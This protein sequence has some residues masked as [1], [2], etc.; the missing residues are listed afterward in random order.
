MRRRLSILISGAS[1]GIGQALALHLAAQGH[2]VFAG[3]RR[4]ADADTLSMQAGERSSLKPLLLD[5][6][7]A[8]SIAQAAA[9]IEALAHGRLDVLINNAGVAFSAPLEMT[10]QQDL[11]RLMGV[12]VLGAFALTRACLPLLRQARGRI[13]N[14]SSISGVFAAPGLSAYVASKHAMEGLTASLRMELAPV[15]VKVCSIAPGKIDTPI[16]D[17]ASATTD[18]LRQINNPLLLALYKPLFDFY[19][20]YASQEIG[21]P[22]SMLI[23]TVE[24]ALAAPAPRARYIVGRQARWRA[25]LNVLPCAWREALVMWAMRRQTPISAPDLRDTQAN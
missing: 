10:P 15:G 24:Q 4:Q 5:V 8:A 22:V 7:Q 19:E 1:S 6:T 20:G 9:A 17:K 21:T 12:N 13:V 3:V 2:T 23:L 16:W 14:I 11:E 25:R 18:L